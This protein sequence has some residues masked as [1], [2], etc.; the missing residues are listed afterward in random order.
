M[1]QVLENVRLFMGGA[2]YTGQSNKIEVAA[3]SEEKDV[4]TFASVDANG[5]LWKD[6]LGGIASAKIAQGGFW[7][8]GDTSRVDDD[9]WAALGGAGAWTGCP[10]AANVGSVALF[11]KA[12]RASYQLGGSV[13]DVAPWTGGLA[14]AFPL[15]RGVCM[16]PPGTARTSTGTGTSVQLTSVAAGKQLYAAAHVLSVAGTGTPT[17]TLKIQS[18]DNTNFTSATDR[19]TFTAATARTGQVLRTPGAI[20]DDW[21][22]V[23]WTISGTGPSF[24]F[25]VSLGIF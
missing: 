18:D 23:A 14:S 9:M 6:V 2:D 19:I 22:R 25:M 24:L 20:A 15:L 16:H 10:I 7:G 11:T 13:G 5:K 17:I 4:T 1:V 3:E 21:Y 12:L 8:A